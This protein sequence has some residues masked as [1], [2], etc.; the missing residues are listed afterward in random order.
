MK[1]TK[2]HIPPQDVVFIGLHTSLWTTS[3]IGNLGHFIFRKRCP[4]IFISMQT[5]HTWCNGNSFKFMTLT[6]F[7]NFLRFAMLRWLNLWCQSA[8]LSFDDFA[9]FA[10]SFWTLTLRR[11]KF[12]FPSC[13]CHH[14][15]M[16]IVHL[17]TILVKLHF[18]A[19]RNEFTNGNE[20]IFHFRNMKNLSDGSKRHFTSNLYCGLWTPFANGLQNGV[21]FHVNLSWN[22]GFINGV[23]GLEETLRGIRAITST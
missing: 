22:N 18:Q 15:S 10:L 12:F 19:F 7:S 17:I 2:Y 20:T 21:I 4:L 8:N 11:Y 9:I 1:V 6:I 13:F 23:L 16:D 3:K 14:D 5:S